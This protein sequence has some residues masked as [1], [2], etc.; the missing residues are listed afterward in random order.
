MSGIIVDFTL[1]DLIQHTDTAVIGKVTEILPVK[2]DEFKSSYLLIYTDVVIQPE[3]YLYGKSE[4]DYIAVRVDGGRI[5]D[6]V[7]VVEDEA[8]FTVGEEC[9]VFLT[10]PTYAHTAPEGFSDD[11][12]Y[13]VWADAKYNILDGILVNGS[14]K[15]FALSDVEQQIATIRGE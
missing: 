8:E 11:N 9:V 6:T 1:D 13:I 3:R 12:Y 7:M 10:H 14:D 15:K 4:A 2:K 5:G